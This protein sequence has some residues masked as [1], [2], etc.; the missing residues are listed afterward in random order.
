MREELLNAKDIAFKYYVVIF[1]FCIWYLN[2]NGGRIK[3]ILDGV[4]DLGLWGVNTI[5]DKLGIIH[6]PFYLLLDI[7]RG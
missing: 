7:Q 6:S 1:M 4:V 2:C 5:K 3:T